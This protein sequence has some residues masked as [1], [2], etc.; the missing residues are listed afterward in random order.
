[1]QLVLVTELA[2]FSVRAPTYF[3][4]K[5]SM[6]NNNVW[7]LFSVLV[8]CIIC[9]FIAVY[10]SELSIINLLWIWLYNI[11]T[12]ILIDIGKV[13]FLNKLIGDTPDEII[14]TDDEFVNVSS[15]NNEV[16]V[17]Q[18]NLLNSIL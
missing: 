14:Q 9:S 8:T 13:Q 16:L 15:I 2:I 12:F 7:L 3:W 10:Y 17:E 6:P 18:E 1:M 11:F 4:R 5:S